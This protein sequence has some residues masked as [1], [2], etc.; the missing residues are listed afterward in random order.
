MAGSFVLCPRD[1]CAEEEAGARIKE[2][3]YMSPELRKIGYVSPEPAQ[4]LGGR[5]R[6]LHIEYRLVAY[7][8][9]PPLVPFLVNHRTRVSGF[10][11]N[12][13]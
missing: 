8:T 4:L 9:E 3:G 10:G 2:I 13:T 6:F 7:H 5:H 1:T 11:Q 12:V